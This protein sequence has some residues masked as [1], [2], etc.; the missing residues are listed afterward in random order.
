MDG[1]KSLIGLNN[2]KEKARVAIDSCKLRLSPLNHLLLTG[3][4]GLGKTALAR[5]IAEE[6]GAYFDEVEAVAF[7]SRDEI[8]KRLV[9]SNRKA[10]EQGK[11][12]VFFIDE[13]H[14]LSLKMQE[15]FY[16]PLKEWRIMESTGVTYLA[17]F[18]LIGATTHED[19]LDQ[20]SFMRRFS[21]IWKLEPYSQD[22]IFS[23]LVDLAIKEKIPFEFSAL[24]IIAERCLGIPRTAHAYFELVRDQALAS[25]KTITREEVEKVFERE[26]INKLGLNQEQVQYLQALKTVK[27]GPRGLAWIASKLKSFPLIVEER[28][29]PALI[30]LGYVDRTSSGRELTEAGMAVC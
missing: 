6:L 3:N 13:I 26:Q 28:V 7:S 27:G 29:E 23:I 10:T 25:G 14:R 9:E 11:F 1:L 15:T 18:T 19:Q 17:P 24:T 2:I 4:G 5:A 22:D 21:Q 16:Y 12:L 8:I 20:A 30:A